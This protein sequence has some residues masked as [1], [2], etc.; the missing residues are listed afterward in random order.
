MPADELQLTRPPTIQSAMRMR[1]PA[2]EVFEAMVN[3]EI[4]TNFW[5]TRSTGRLAPGAAVLWSWE[6]YGISAPVGVAEFE[7]DR[8]LL[9]QMSE[10]PSAHTVEWRFDGRPDDTTNVTVT[11]VEPPPF[12]DSGD[13]LVAWALDQ[14]GGYAQV[15]AALKAWLEH[16][17]VLTL[18][19]DAWPDGHP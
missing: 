3:P 1:R 13:T 6:M 15:L 8:R 14:A 5:F 19:L 4:T 11:I 17:V 9:L 10:G 18:V 16:G 7:P 2:G 12:A